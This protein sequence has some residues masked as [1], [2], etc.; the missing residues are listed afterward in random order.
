MRGDDD[1]IYYGRWV[2]NKVIRSLRLEDRL[3][4]NQIITQRPRTQ[5]RKYLPISNK[6]VSTHNGF[7][8]YDPP[9]S[10]IALSELESH[11]GENFNLKHYEHLLNEID[12]YK[13]FLKKETTFE[14]KDDKQPDSLVGGKATL[15]KI[16]DTKIQFVET[17]SNYWEKISS[18]LKYVAIVAI[19][20]LIATIA[21]GLSIKCCWK[22]KIS[23]TLSPS[24]LREE[25]TEP[26]PMMT[27][28]KQKNKNCDK[29]ITIRNVE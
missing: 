29:N 25:S 15:Y 19:I 24:A 20:I 13:N 28:A 5:W 1:V 27:F 9:G 26:V 3:N 4:P 18:S 11:V 21:I 8:I 17:I 6:I 7:E 22:R 16:F 2:H 12:L 23:I 14:T 10:V